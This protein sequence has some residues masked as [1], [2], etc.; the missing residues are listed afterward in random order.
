METKEHILENTLLGIQNITPIYY[1]NPTHQDQ[2][3]Q[4]YAIITS[5]RL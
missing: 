5:I 4:T 3:H 2:G 1:I